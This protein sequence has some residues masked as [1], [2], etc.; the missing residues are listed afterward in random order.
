MGNQLLPSKKGLCLL[1]DACMVNQI[2]P[3]TR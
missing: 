2:M 1:L 3:S